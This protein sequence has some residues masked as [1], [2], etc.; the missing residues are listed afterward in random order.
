MFRKALGKP[1][2]REGERA[3]AACLFVNDT[4]NDAVLQRL[5]EGGVRFLV[6]RC[7]S[8]CAQ[9][10]CSLSRVAPGLWQQQAAGSRSMEQ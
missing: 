10:A 9:R 6:R 3:G 2:D 1:A 5:A 8:S 7:A 4:A